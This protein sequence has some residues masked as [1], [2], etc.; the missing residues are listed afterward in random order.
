ML[1]ISGIFKKIK[2]GRGFVQSGRIRHGDEERKD[3]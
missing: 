2:K 3:G 1:F